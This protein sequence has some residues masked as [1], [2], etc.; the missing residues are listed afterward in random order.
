MRIDL[1]DYSYTET[2]RVTR[3]MRRW[4][5]EQSLRRKLP[6]A[7]IIREALDAYRAAMERMEATRQCLQH[8]QKRWLGKTMVNRRNA[9]TGKTGEALSVDF[10]RMSLR[11]EYVN[12]RCVGQPR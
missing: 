3:T 4:L 6:K 7:L 2:A 8:G 5:R 1:G 12:S 10:G 9:T 11:D